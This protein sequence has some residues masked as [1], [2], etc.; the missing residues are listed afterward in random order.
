MSKRPISLLRLSRH[1]VFDLLRLEEVLLRRSNK[2]WCIVNDGVPK[3]AAVMGISGKTES[4]INVAEAKEQRVELIKRFTGGG[5]V[6]LDQDSILVSLICE[7]EQTPEVPLFPR[8][9]MQWSQKF[10]EPVFSASGDF[11]L[12]ETGKE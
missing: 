7:A 4:L 12:S 6:V 2:S 11:K 1:C 3:P 10:Y 5:T 9:L 8:P